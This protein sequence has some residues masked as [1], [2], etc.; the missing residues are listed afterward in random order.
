MTS[1]VNSDTQQGELRDESTAD[2]VRQLAQETRTLVKQELDFA[3]AEATRVGEGVITLARR[4][5]GMIYNSNHYENS[6]LT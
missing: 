1:P 3:R 6:I 2:L 4:S 5:W